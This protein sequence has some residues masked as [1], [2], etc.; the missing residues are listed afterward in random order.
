MD[1]IQATQEI[2]KWESTT[3]EQLRH[4]IIA[5]TA[6]VMPGIYY[7]FLQVSRVTNFLLRNK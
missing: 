6:D 1:G 7:F 5:L 3:Q 2:R 4:T